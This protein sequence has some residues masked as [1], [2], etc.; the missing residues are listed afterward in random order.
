[1]VIALI[2]GIADAFLDTLALPSEV[3][4]KQSIELSVIA[5]AL[6]FLSLHAPGV[7]QSL[8]SGTPQLT[9]GTIATSAAAAGYMSSKAASSVSGGASATIRAAGAMH[10]NGA[11]AAS[12]TSSVSEE[13]SALGKAAKMASKA[14]LYAVG[15]AGG[16]VAGAG[17]EALGQSSYEQSRDYRMKTNDTTL[18]RAG[19]T[20]PSVEGI[21]GNFNSGKFSVAGYR[22]A[23]SAKERTKGEKADQKTTASARQEAS[24]KQEPNSSS[25]QKSTEGN[26]EKP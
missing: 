19:E 20:N 4:W 9:F 26:K 1:M 10:G 15:S 18:R 14:S 12:S 8:L 21:R 17:K 13:K 16:L 6:A 25:K 2:I 24:A 5:L 11:A 22:D 3:T 7:A 23:H